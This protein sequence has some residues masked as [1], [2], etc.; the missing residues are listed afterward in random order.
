MSNLIRA[1][2]PIR[3]TLSSSTIQP[4]HIFDGRRVG[5]VTPIQAAT[6]S[7][8][9]QTT[10]S[11]QWHLRAAPRAALCARSGELDVVLYAPCVAP[12]AVRCG[13][14]VVPG[15][16]PYPTSAPQREAWRAASSG[17]WHLTPSA[18]QAKSPFQTQRRTQKEQERFDDSALIANVH[19][20]LAPGLLPHLH[21]AQ[22]SG[23]G[24]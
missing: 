15:A 7:R 23:R 14:C 20:Y 8:K 4:P 19:S 24:C 6:R 22:I 11:L 1:L 17:H 3:E 9:L 21:V 5:R 12:D 16:V 2:D 13:P 10:F 18:M